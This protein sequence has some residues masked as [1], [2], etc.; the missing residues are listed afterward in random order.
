[1]SFSELHASEVKEKLLKIR[2][3]LS[4]ENL[5][6]I[7]LRGVDWFAWA[8]CGGDSSVI[9]STETGIAD[10]FVTQAKAL[11]LTSKIETTR[12]E[13]EEVPS[14]FDVLSFPWSDAGALEREVEA[15]RKEWPRMASDR[16][17]AGQLGLSPAWTAAKL[18][19]SS[20]EIER[21]RRLGREAAEAATEVLSQITP[22]TTEWELA[23][24][25]ANALWARGIHPLLTLVGGA[26]RSIAYRHP[27]A[28]NVA[29]G[30][31]AVLVIC[32]RK[33]GL[34]ANFTRHVYFRDFSS[35]EIRKNEALTRIEAEAFSATRDLATLPQTYERIREKYAMLG[36]ADEI[37]CHHQGGPTGYLS[38]ETMARPEGG[39][40][41][42]PGRSRAFAWNPSLSGGLKLEDTV[43][44]NSEGQIEI[45]TLDP[46]WPSTLV[47]GLSRPLALRKK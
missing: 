42:P 33:E 21:Y 13:K 12:L 10:V 39:S 34:Y 35:E 38:R 17:S 37:G 7:H 28:K 23:G 15:L 24:K 11:I 47:Q 8:T 41:P 45:L 18:D 27:V 29:V 2:A 26:E 46:K 3:L 4:Q 36:F 44:L 25:A 43:L 5:D 14:G 31:H 32:G 19:L 20:A 22:E 1:M 9:F 30:D 40:F 6:A 16:P